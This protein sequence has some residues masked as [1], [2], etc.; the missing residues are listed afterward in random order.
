M[1]RPVCHTVRDGRASLSHRGRA[2]RRTC[3]RFF[4]FWPWGAYPWAEG[5]RKGRW[6]TIHL[7]LPSYKISAR[8]HK[9]CTRYALPKFF[10]FWRWFWPLKVIQG[11]SDGA[12]GKPVVPT[13]KYSPGS[14]V[15]SVTVF[16]IF[17]VKILT[18]DLLTLAGLTPRPK[19]TKKAD[20]L[21]ST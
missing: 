18:V 16:E 10:T 7:D 3:Y 13:I 1:P 14:N 4:N 12:N 6:T 9:G 19:V 11:Q 17:R 15:V 5:H 8:S 2:G 20:D 21:L